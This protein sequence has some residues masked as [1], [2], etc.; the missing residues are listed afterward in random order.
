M[1]LATYITRAALALSLTLPTSQAV[2]DP[3]WPASVA[4]A[5][6]QIFGGGRRP[7]YRIPPTNVRAEDYRALFG[8]TV[9]V[10]PGNKDGKDSVPK[11][12][13]KFVFIG[14]DG[15]YVWCYIR[16]DGEYH[17]SDVRWRP[18]KIRRGKV[19][20]PLFDNDAEKQKL[21]GLAP[22]YDAATGEAI[23]YTRWYRD[24]R[25]WDHNV[26][27]HQERLPASTWTLCPDFPSAEEL[28]VGIN[29]KQTALTYD[30]LI[31]QDPGRRILRPDLVT[32]N[33]VEVVE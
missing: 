20:Y 6:A 22:F 12:A 10:I 5:R 15:R 17:T 30:K 9:M 29:H 8:D 21:R 7:S 2:A 28:G 11:N 33:A 13:L 16:T 24:K 26:G 1:R 25:W 4:E 31:A 19:V 14:R 23:W 32:P 3:S 18:L 27:H